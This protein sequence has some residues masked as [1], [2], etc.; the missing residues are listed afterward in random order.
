[1]K[2]ITPILVLVLVSIY[3]FANGT[4]DTV[5]RIPIDETNIA[6]PGFEIQRGVSYSVEAFYNITQGYIEIEY[7]GIG[8]AN[9]YIF[10]RQNQVVESNTLHKENTW[11]LVNI[12][13]ISGI[14]TIVVLSDNYYGSGT[15]VIE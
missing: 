5:Q 15:F 9:V 3:S 8:D 11:A 13:D 14:Y 10:N 2:R 4:S 6:T 7:D 12:P 1:M